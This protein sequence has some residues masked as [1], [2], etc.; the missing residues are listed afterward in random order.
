[1]TAPGRRRGAV[2]SRRGGYVGL[3]CQIDGF[4]VGLEGGKYGLASIRQLVRVADVMRIIP[5][6]P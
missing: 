5:H 3:K 2:N 1:L 6:S 4:E